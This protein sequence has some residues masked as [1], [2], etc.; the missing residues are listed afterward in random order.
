MFKNKS[1]FGA[2]VWRKKGESLEWF[3]ML[4][5]VVYQIRHA[6]FY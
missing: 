3:N 6:H 2:F 1:A 4:L 5:F